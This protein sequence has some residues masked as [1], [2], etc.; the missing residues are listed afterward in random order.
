MNVVVLLYGSDLSMLELCFYK[1][2]FLYGSGWEL[3][4]REMRMQNEA[5]AVTL[6][7]LSE[8]DVVRNKHRIWQRVP[9]C[10]HSPLILW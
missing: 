4:K 8:L 9:A 3:D 6:W 7:E 10:P 1:T 5:V 2:H